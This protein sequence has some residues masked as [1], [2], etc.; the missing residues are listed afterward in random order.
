M[1]RAQLSLP[2]FLAMAL[3]AQS[4]EAASITPLLSG[5]G[6]LHLTFLP[7]RLYVKNLSLRYL[8]QQAYDVPDF[9]LTGPEADLQRH[10]D[11]QATSGA[12]VSRA[13]M[14]TMLRNLLGERFHLQTHWETR[15]ESAYRMVV[16]PGRSKI[17]TSEIGYAGGNSPLRDGNS[18]QLNGPMSMRQLAER[19]NQFLHKPV[20]DATNLDGYF[21]IALTFAAEDFDA[22]KD[23]GVPLPSLP[24]ALEEQM[25]LKLIAGKEPIQR[26]VVDHA[27]AVPTR[28]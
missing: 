27:D 6:P 26:L 10:F 12:A 18:I 25:G 22:T 20:V 14:L 11:I 15:T 2:V 21:T 23:V 7:N 16:V 24:Q 28:N 17:K 9:L 1:A 8:I 13:E 19:L 5:Y 3:H 4:F